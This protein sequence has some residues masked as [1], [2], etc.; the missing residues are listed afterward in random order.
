METFESPYL[1]VACEQ[2]N[3]AMCSYLVSIRHAQSVLRASFEVDLFI[4]PNVA[5]VEDAAD[6]RCHTYRP[7][8]HHIA[9]SGQMP[10]RK[11]LALN[12]FGPYDRTLLTA[13][14]V[15]W[16]EEITSVETVS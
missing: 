14:F 13:Y 8:R 6:S 9:R 7:V 15:V 16:A 3:E 5:K 11:S 4:T 10:A 1:G 12:P 2:G